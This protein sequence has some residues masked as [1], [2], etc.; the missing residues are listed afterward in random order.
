MLRAYSLLRVKQNAPFHTPYS[1]Q[2][3]WGYFI[4]TGIV[5]GDE[6]GTDGTCAPYA[7]P[8]CRCVGWDGGQ[9][10]GAVPRYVCAW[11]R[12]IR[13]QSFTAARLSCRDAPPPPPRDRSHHEP[14]KYPACASTEYN[15]PACPTA[16]SSST[17]SLQ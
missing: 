1:L 3:A 6:Y 7:F 12:S 4:N 2:E 10:A 17:R 5:T 11:Q 16:V 15:T 8:Q 14:G 9:W 13:A